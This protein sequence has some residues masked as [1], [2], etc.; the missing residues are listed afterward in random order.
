MKVRDS[1]RHYQ[2]SL[3]SEAQ[4]PVFFERD[5][6]FSSDNITIFLR[7]FEIVRQREVPVNR[8][9]VRHLLLFFDRIICPL[10]VARPYIYRV[11][12][13]IRVS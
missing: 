4:R 12:N 11:E 3:A 2:R 13:G 9:A 6:G 1:T 7:E 8:P 5:H 10:Y